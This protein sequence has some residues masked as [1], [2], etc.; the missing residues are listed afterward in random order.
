MKF[1]I[2][3]TYEKDIYK[4][5]VLS[6]DSDKDL[7]QFTVKLEFK[8]RQNHRL[9]MKSFLNHIKHVK[10]FYVELLDKVINETYSGFIILTSFNPLA[11]VP[12]LIVLISKLLESFRGLMNFQIP[13][14]D[15]YDIDTFLSL[16]DAI[17]AQL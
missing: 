3:W 7:L 17:S 16:N 5:I 10:E 8:I 1:Y 4:R 11:S 14:P 15:K 2:L 12:L 6:D 13:T 9:E